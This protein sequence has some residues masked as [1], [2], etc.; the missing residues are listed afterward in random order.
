MVGRRAREGSGALL[1]ASVLW[2]TTGTAQALAD[3]GASPAVVGAAR[4]AVGG[5]VLVAACVVLGRGGSALALWRGPALR[6]TLAAAG[7]AAV[8]QPVFFAAVDRT[9]VAV[10]TLVALGSAPAFCGGLARWW[11]REPLPPGWVPATGAAVLGCALIVLPGADAAVQPA[12][13]AL[14]LLA[15]A[16]YAVYTVS[17]KRLL[18]AGHDAVG[19]LAATLGGAALVLAPVLAGAP[20]E[21]LGAGGVALVAWLGIAATA[22]AYGLFARGL[23]RVPAATAG[24]LSLAEPQTAVALGLLV[25]G[26]RPAA[27]AGLGTVLL[28]AGLVAA[29]LAPQRARSSVPTGPAGARPR[30][31]PVAE[32]ERPGMVTR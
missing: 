32:P 3:V 17:A 31:E 19:V 12:G 6:W 5:S 18:S 28:S 25:L 10:G 16:C 27:A 4:L 20:G 29:A 1:G 2:G 23:G 14:A 30:P 9:G 8:F 11:T 24:T 21:L 26:E 22:V 7:A 13:V 15:G